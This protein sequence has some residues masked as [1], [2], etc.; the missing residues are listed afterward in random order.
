MS[1][2][3]GLKYRDALVPNLLVLLYVVAGYGGGLY[4]LITGD[5]QS[6]ALAVLW[7]A[8]ALVIAAYL[9]HECAHNTIFASNERNAA[10]GRVLTWLVGACYSDY[11]KIRDKHFRHHVDQADVIAIDFRPLLRRHPRLLKIIYGFEWFYIPLFD[12][13]MHLAAIL[14]PFLMPSRA[15]QRKS[16]IVVVLVRAT[17]FGVLLWYAPKAALGYV[18][19]YSLTL[20]VL[21]FMDAFQHTFAVSTLL[22]GERPPVKK[23]RDYEQGNTF[24]NPI[25]PT[26]PL[27]NWLTLNF[28]FHNAHH[29]KPN[30]PWYRLPRLHRELFGDPH[31]QVLP[32]LNQ[33]KAYHRYRLQRILNEDPPGLDV[34]GSRG[35]QFIGVVGVSFLTAF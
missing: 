3:L 18:I 35:E 2:L 24:S 8:H 27:V 20:H 33:L 17:L 25:A 12:W 5:W 13:L 10:L 9:I 11:A 7:L 28:G 22:D 29:E 6:F 1:Q 30:E 14:V 16:V 34:M 19:A 21:R 31:Y 26:L 23:N 15:A 4:L 32:F